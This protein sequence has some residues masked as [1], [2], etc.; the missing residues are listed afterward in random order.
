MADNET[1]QHGGTA[2]PLEDALTNT[3]LKD[4]DPAVYYAL[5]FF[6]AMLTEYIG[7]RLVAQA[8]AASAPIASAVAMVVPFDP[9]PFLTETQ[10]KFPL[11]AIS[12][13]SETFNEASVAWPRRVG[14]WSCMYILPP[15]TAGQMEAIAPILATIG[16]VLNGRALLGHD[17]SYASDASVWT[18]AGLER[19]KVMSASFGAFEGAQGLVLPCWSAI[20]EVNERASEVE[21]GFEEFAGA[22][23]TVD[24]EA[25]DE[26]VLATIVQI[27]TQ[28]APT[29]TSAAP[30]SGSKAG[31]VA[32]T[33]VGT[34][35]Q[36]PLTVTVGGIPCTSVVVAPALITCVTGAHDAYTSF[37]ADVV[38]TNA[39]GQTASLIAGFT[40]TTP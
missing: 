17:P 25:A 7:D 34:L 5:D 9:V 11:L 26:T 32:L 8:T 22:D 40:Y 21:D 19:V 23:A 14:Q 30:S 13:K 10:F 27:S 33:L 20:L 6:S 35:F 29:L 18:T 37:I 38:V 3:L 2:Y 15:L 12:R 28:A 39:D 1:F 24:L 31:G 16:P 36:G 4:A